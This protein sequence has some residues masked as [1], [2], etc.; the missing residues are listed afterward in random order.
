MQKLPEIESE[1]IYHIYTYTKRNTKKNSLN[2]MERS[3]NGSTEI[4]KE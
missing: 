2:K 3:I 4:S 1:R